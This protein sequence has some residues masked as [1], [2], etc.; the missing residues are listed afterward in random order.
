M[1]DQ[2]EARGVCFWPLGNFSTISDTVQKEGTPLNT[3]IG[4][5]PVTESFGITTEL[6]SETSGFAFAQMVFSKWQRVPGSPNNPESLAAQYIAEARKRRGMKEN[7][8]TVEDY[9]DK[10]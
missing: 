7:I 8:P 4:E 1:V 10:L 5:L 6:R 9:S 3:V 2:L